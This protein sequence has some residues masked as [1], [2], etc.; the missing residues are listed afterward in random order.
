MMDINFG[1]EHEVVT[2]GGALAP[3]LRQNVVL[4][5][6]ISFAATAALAACEAC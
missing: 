1:L 5:A 6:G 2:N 3:V 4:H